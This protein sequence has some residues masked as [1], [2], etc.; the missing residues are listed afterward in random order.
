MPISSRK[1]RSNKRVSTFRGWRLPVLLTAIVSCNIAVAGDET[2]DELW[3]EEP[4]DVVFS[5]GNMTQSAREMGLTD[6]AFASILRTSL[7]RAGLKARQSDSR[8]DDDLIFLD[9][10]VEDETFYASIGFW[11]RVNIRLP[12]EE[13]YSKFVTV[14]QDYSVGA[15][16]GDPG[17]VRDTVH[18]VIDR[19]IASYGAANDVS[20]PLLLSATP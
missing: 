2:S 12:N 15:H 16:H 3:V 8:H 11:R 19:F 18:K 4:R 14:W 13:F 6:A 20:M 9:I 10:I 7:N 5:I 17:R 1:T